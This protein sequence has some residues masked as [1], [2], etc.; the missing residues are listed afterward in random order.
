MSAQPLRVKAFEL[1]ERL[2]I[3]AY[4]LMSRMSMPEILDWIEYDAQH[5]DPSWYPHA[6][7]MALI[8]NFTSKKRRHPKEFLPKMKK[9]RRR[10]RGRPVAEIRRDLLLS[11]GVV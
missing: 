8:A 2:G 10:R 3:P 4:E 7:L 5:F 11:I 1:S 6:N 9:V